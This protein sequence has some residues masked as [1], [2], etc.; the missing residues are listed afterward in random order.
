MF[1]FF[2]QLDGGEGESPDESPFAVSI[3]NVELFP[4]FSVGNVDDVDDDKADGKSSPV[5]GPLGAGIGPLWGNWFES[6]KSLF[7]GTFKAGNGLVPVPAGD[8]PGLRRKKKKIE[9]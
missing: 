3:T 9:K 2:N 6:G 4:P 8:D 1:F 7:T 5:W